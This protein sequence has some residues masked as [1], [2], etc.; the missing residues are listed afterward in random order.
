MCN[1]TRKLGK[2]DT[3]TL[4]YLDCHERQH[5]ASKKGLSNNACQETFIARFLGNMRSAG[6]VPALSHLRISTTVQCTYP[7][8]VKYFKKAY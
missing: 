3:M 2:L 5:K 8:W 6:L 1:I 7:L 4:K